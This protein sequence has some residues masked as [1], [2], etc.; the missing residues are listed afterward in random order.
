MSAALFQRH[1]FEHTLDWDFT[2]IWQW[3]DVKGHPVLQSVGVG[4][5]VNSGTHALVDPQ[6]DDLL[7]QQM[8]ANLWL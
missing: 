2:N 3:D 7:T 6:A 1:Y 5:N 8:R 4:A